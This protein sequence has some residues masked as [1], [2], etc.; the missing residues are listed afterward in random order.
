[1]N[2][3]FLKMLRFELRGNLILVTLLF[4][5]VLLFLMTLVIL[6]PGND[7]KVQFVFIYTFVTL[8]QQGIRYFSIETQFPHSMQMYLLIPVSQKIKFFSKLFI[9]LVIFPFLFLL[10][11]FVSVS[12]AHLVTGKS[13]SLT[14]IGLTNQNILAFT[15]FFV[16]ASSIGT[17]TAII[18]KKY[19]SLLL[20]MAFIILYMTAFLVSWLLGWCENFDSFYYLVVDQ[21]QKMSG[22]IVVLLSTFF[23]G[24]SY[25]LFF[26]RQL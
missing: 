10:S 13:A 3:S 23:Y 2:Y 12:L 11:G 22:I 24:L 17:L 7:L 21:I 6:I 20:V 15:I 26:R 18:A 25:R 5:L 1:M 14:S 9:S 4:T 8:V 19:A 16:L